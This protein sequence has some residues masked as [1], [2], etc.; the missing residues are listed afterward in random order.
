M[1]HWLVEGFACAL[2]RGFFY[3]TDSGAYRHRCLYIRKRA[4]AA[5][6]RDAIK[7]VCV[8]VCVCLYIRTQN[9]VCVCVCVCVRARAH[10]RVGGA[11]E[12]R[13]QRCVC[14]CE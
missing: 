11:A 3:V 8:R 14:V 4:W 13:H 7:G 5:L 2:L 12:G 6:Q 10:C 1:F 9:C